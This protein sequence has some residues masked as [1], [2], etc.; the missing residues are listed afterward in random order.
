MTISSPNLLLSSDWETLDYPF[1]SDH[2]PIIIK[3]SVSPAS[4]SKRYPGALNNHDFNFNKADWS[5]F[6]LSVES[7]MSISYPDN[8]IAAYSTFTSVVI[9]AAS[10]S[11]LKY[12]THQN[13]CSS[14]VWWNADCTKAVK[15]RTNCFHLFRRS[16][17]MSDFFKI[18]NQCAVTRRVLNSNSLS[19]PLGKTIL[20]PYILLLPLGNSGTLP[21]SFKMHF[22]NNDSYKRRLVR[23]GISISF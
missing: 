23:L 2:F 8:P 6:S 11:I 14:P 21:R 1:S 16:R 15:D 22:P 19:Y 20:L 18:K 17:S 12:V 4:L 13:F 7:L 3:F 9:S 5:I 10:Q